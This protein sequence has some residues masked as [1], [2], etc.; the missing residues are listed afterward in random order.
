MERPVSVTK[1]ARPRTRDFG[2]SKKLADFEPLNF[3]LNGQTFNC[4]P[5][6]QGQTMLQ[7]VS[8]ADSNDGG[9]A[10]SALYKFF[11]QALVTED[12]PRFAEMLVSEEY[13]VDLSLLGDIAGWLVEE[14]TS[15]PTSEPKS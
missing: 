3:S 15:R 9:K 5:A 8:D 10:A 4:R 14:Y 1:E 2:T 11:E 13:I 6:I 7:F 12:Y